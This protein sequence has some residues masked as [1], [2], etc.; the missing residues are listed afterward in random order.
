MVG[1]GRPSAWKYFAH[2]PALLQI[3]LG[4]ARHLFCG[5]VLA[6]CCLSLSAECSATEKTV[7]LRIAWGSGTAAKQRW[8]G[9]ISIDGSLLTELQPLGI[10]ADAPVALR[11]EGSRLV[12]AP[13]ENRE[14]D[15]C[16]V[17]VRADEQ[18][19]VRVEIRSQGNEK[20]QAA[21]FEATLAEVL[22]NQL[23]RRLDEQGGFF[24]ARR[25]PGD[26]LRVL[27]TREHLVF[28]P[29]EKWTLK[30]QPDLA[31]QLAGGPL[32]L[33]VQLRANG[34]SKPS[35]RS[36]QQITE[37]SQL[38]NGIEFQI[39]CPPTEGAYRLTI[40]ARPEEGFATRF[41][42]GQ[43]TKL[44]ATRDIEFVVIDPAA[45]LPNLVDQWLPLLT[46]DPANPSW[47]QR[48]PSWAQ[49]PRFRERNQAA[50]G[51]V[52]PVVRLTPTGDLV[53]L[54]PATAGSDPSWQ[55]Y[56]LP[57]REPG[58]PHLVEIEYPAGAEQHLAI[59]LVEPD[60]AGRVT[61]TQQD[62]SLFSEGS[63]TAGD[64][65]VA[66]HRFVVWPRTNSPQLL[67][68]N[69]HPALPGK[70]GKINL[71]RQD[72]SLAALT[73]LSFADPN[74]RLVAGYLAKPLLTQN[75]GAAE[76]FD[77]GSGTSIQSWA[78]FL[79][80][81]R[82]LAQ[83][84]RLGGY[85]GVMI[86]VAAD[87]SSLY[88]SRVLQ[89]SPRYDTGLLATSGQDPVRKDVLEML[90]RIFDREGIR[91]VP[92]VQL[93]APLPHLEVLRLARDV[94]TTGIGCVGPYGQSWFAENATHGGL[95]SFYNPLN[96]QVQAAIVDVVT[97]L[98][99]RYKEHASLAGLGVQ[100]S[101]EGYGLMPGLAWGMDD[102]TVR[103]FSQATGIA[104]PRQGRK[105]FRQRAN[106]LHGEHRQ[107][108]Q[109]WRTEKLTQ[110]YTRLAKQ[111]AT[112][113]SDLRLILAT[114]E[115]FSGTELRQRVRQAIATPLPLNEVLLE[116]GLDLPQ[117]GAL[118]GVTTLAPRFLSVTD[119]L[120][121]RALDIRL[122]TAA[123]QGEYL[124]AEQHSAE[125]FFHA[126]RRFR[127]AS[128]DQRSP[129]GAEQ[130]FLTVI[131][132]A[133]SAGVKLR[134]HMLTALAA[135]DAQTVV[136]GGIQLPLSPGS[137]SQRILKTVQ[138]L[139]NITT[140]TR[141]YRQQPLVMRVYRTEVATIVSLINESPWSVQAEV[142]LTV[143]Q[144]ADWRKLGNDTNLNGEPLAGALNEREEPWQ[145]D[146]L[147]Y[148][149]QAWRFEDEKLRVGELK[150]TLSTLAKLEL[151]Y[152]IQEI[153]SRA[154]NLNVERAFSPLQN[155]GFEQDPSTTSIP[156]WQTRQGTVG[157]I[158][159]E[160][161]G[162][163]S[164]A[165]ALRLQSEDTTGVAVQSLPFAAP[166]T[167]QLMVSV[168]LRFDQLDEGAQLQIVVQDQHE[169]RHYRQFTAIINQQLAGKGWQRFEFP[170]EDVPSGEGEQLQLHFHLIGDAEVLVDDIQLI[171]LRFNEA[172]RR[173]LVKR[174]YAAKI[175]LEQEKVVDC[176][177]VVDD[178]WSRYLVEHVQP[179]NQAASIA[180]K[181]TPV[182]EPK[183]E[184]EKGIGSR[185]RGWVPKIWR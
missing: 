80:G 138:Q 38:E 142:P 185:V 75:F 72:A 140:S 134:H 145:V 33:D 144:T 31:P 47:W 101:G 171:D 96:D 147:P 60:A 85:N 56:T 167:G 178:Y 112:E 40:T 90:L 69:R 105:R 15:G 88:P 45:K 102:N 28:N 135:D 109:K 179:I 103:E 129:F 63:S 48:L 19:L 99:A 163:H 126:T 86:S 36:S 81:T 123:E 137:T 84:L 175:S 113:R 43:Q 4:S 22:N 49:V 115:L 146:L 110:L 71:L 11:I 78:T 89:P 132:Q 149:L 51:N 79:D 29:K 108:W 35:W 91:V 8:T 57:V 21:I 44:I 73:D 54:P 106:M 118:P 59:S 82:R 120:Q 30:L 26:V 172:R 154:G 128:F 157:E 177:R 77:A 2:R 160:N 66:V 139:P 5:L 170:L 46:I 53:E 111:V 98:T 97:E 159:L 136:T 151:E 143:S 10:E 1:Q 17:M 116:H 67:I 58:Q 152:R 9:Q 7:R 176:L 183:D 3:G 158:T 161:T 42:P 124:S 93:A 181:Q 141:I 182:T 6:F 14:F 153:E 122:N 52:R 34:Q 74:A 114:E 76:M 62:A 133:R 184:E 20:A 13:L 119:T 125:L 164:G 162:S 24:L 155:P 173:A 12:I 94:Q 27:P 68:V 117:I 148:D 23:G 166:D 174:I 37:A 100:I 169:G 104:T 32:L 55:S 18:A 95:G 50:V 41:V 70:Y 150:T 16:D 64:G 156:D 127:L 87:G 165:R 121:D 65:E 25:S 131:S 130:S 92:T 168:Y 180:T 39:E 107:A 61:T 83:A